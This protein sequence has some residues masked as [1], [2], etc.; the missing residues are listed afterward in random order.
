VS[1]FRDALEHVERNLGG[2]LSLHALARRFE[3]SPWHFHRGFRRET[4]EAPASY[5]RRL[6]LELAAV[7]LKHSDGRVT[8]IAFR[9]GYETHEA[10]T[11]AFRARLGIAPIEFRR[12]W[13]AAQA[14]GG[15][16]IVRLP[17]AGS[18]A[19]A[20]WDRTHARRTLS[21]RS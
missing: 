21:M 4:G 10:F 12:R 3:M 6:R 11:R 5:V 8:E 1:F 17:R 19:F 15:G 16:R 18:H 20:T 9:I 7:L 14:A 2:D 13:P